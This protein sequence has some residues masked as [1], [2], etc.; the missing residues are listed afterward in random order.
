ML[1]INVREARQ[2][3][4]E[5]LDLVESGEEVILLRHGEATARLT[6]PVVMARRLPSMKEFRGSLGAVSEASSTALLQE[7]RD[8]R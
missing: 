1:E 7:E 4:S 6:T 8:D 2:K 3:L 5:L